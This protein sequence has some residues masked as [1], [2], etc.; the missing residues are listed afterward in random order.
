MSSSQVESSAPTSDEFLTAL[1][2]AYHHVKRMRRSIRMDDS[3]SGGLG[4]DSLA[5]VELL[6]SLEQRYGIELI[7][8]EE[9]ARAQTVADLHTLVTKLVS[10]TA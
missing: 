8:T 4:L 7:D 5:A 9:V 2:D 10:R 1:E 6:L 3:L